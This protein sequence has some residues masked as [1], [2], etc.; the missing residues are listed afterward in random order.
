MKIEGVFPG[1]A[2]KEG[3]LKVSII[4]EEQVHLLMAPGCEKAPLG[5]YVMTYVHITALMNI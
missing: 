2:T 3:T 4:C 1:G 5:V